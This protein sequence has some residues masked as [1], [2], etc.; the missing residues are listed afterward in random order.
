MN[1]HFKKIILS[2]TI[3]GLSVVP[4]F[5]AIGYTPQRA[6][7]IKP[8]ADFEMHIVRPDVHLIQDQIG[9][10][11]GG[12]LGEGDD[13]FER[14]DSESDDRFRELAANANAKSA[15]AQPVILL[16]EEGENFCRLLDAALRIDCL[17]ES[18]ERTAETLANTGD[19]AT[20]KKSLN[21]AA[22]KLRSIVR[23][24]RDTTANRVTAEVKSRQVNRK[25]SRPLTPVK[26]E[27]IPQANREARAVVDELS[28]VLL[29]SAE[30]SDK[31]AAYYTQIAS[32]VDSNKVLLR[33]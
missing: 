33:S 27:S 18:Y 31:R 25:A 20:V 26:K 24:N 16:V 28:T 9:G 7:L 6:P 1:M 3:V 8:T 2:S 10:E 4:V 19:E 32:A 14:G 13:E 5:A 12:E 30:N 29:R 11:Y 22:S 23:E 21:D 17:A 15:A